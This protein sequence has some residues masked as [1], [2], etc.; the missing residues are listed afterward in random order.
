MPKPNELFPNK[1]L[2]DPVFEVLVVPPNPNPVDAVEFTPNKFVDPAGVAVVVVPAAV[3]VF[4]N[5]DPV[6]GGF[7]A[8]LPNKDPAAGGFV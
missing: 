6:A 3:A 5:N 1:V 7:V 8:V 2:C 4:P